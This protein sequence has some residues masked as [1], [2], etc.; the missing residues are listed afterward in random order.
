MSSDFNVAFI[1]PTG[2]GC[3]IGGH[4]GDATPAAKLIAETCDKILLNP[5]VVNAS[6][7]N[8]MPENGL[9]VEGSI[10]D[11]F[12]RGEY[13]LE[14]VRSNRIA[15]VVNKPAR[16]DTIN[17]VNASITTLGID[18]EIVELDKELFMSGFYKDGL[19]TGHHAGI[20]ELIY[21][22]K[23]LNNFDAF[24]IATEINVDEKTA[25]EY[26]TDS[27]KLNPWGWIEARV[28]NTIAKALKKPVAHAP[29]EIGA[30]TNEALFNLPFQHVVDPRKAPEVISNCFL[31]CVMKGLHKAPRIRDIGIH[32]NSIAALIT[33][34][35]CWDEAHAACYSAGIPIIAVK[36]NASMAGK[37]AF[38]AIHV[39]N[40]LE[41]AGV[42]LCMKAGIKTNS[43]RKQTYG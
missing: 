18:A 30:L 11:G 26:F 40:Y 23:P 6:D 41:A 9:Y 43:V 4:A 35:Y 38:D 19:P 34:D 16:P 27:N 12:L 2:I 25:L 24:A 33:P 28:S 22:L 1:I 13:M 39:E 8:E 5:N 14:E 10:L 31:H 17:A 36:E 3:A 20:N 29:I 37:V 32:R 42:L 21:Q 15:V 7:I